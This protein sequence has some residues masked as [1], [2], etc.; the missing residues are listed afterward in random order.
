[1]KNLTIKTQLVLA[2]LF[3]GIL[4]FVVMGITSFTKAE[5]AISVEAF[6][7]LEAVRDIKKNQLEQFFRYRKSDLEVL[8]VSDNV[9]SF[10]NELII[11]HNDLEVKD[12][13]NYPVSSEKVKS[14]TS[15]YH[16]YFQK[17]NDTYGYYDVFLICAKHGHIMYSVAKE[18]DYGENLSMGKLRDSGLG[19]LWKMVTRSGKASLVDMR[20]YAPSNDEPAMFMGV[21]V[22]ENGKQI[23]VLAIQVSDKAITAITSGR[24]GMGDTGE[25]YLV[26]EDK[27]MRSDSFLDPVNHS[28][29]ASFANPAKGSVT[30]DAVVNALTGKT[31]TEIVIDYNN[32]PVL[33]AYQPLEFTKHFNAN[34]KWIVLAEI[35]EA[36]VTI[37]TESLK[38]S[39]LI[40]GVVFLV[41]I[42][43]IALVLGNM[44]SKPIFE[45]VRSI[46]ESNK[47]VVSASSEIS[48][49]ATSLAE[50]ASN[51]ASSVEEVSATIKESTAIN[52][53]NS[54]NSN[55]ADILAKTTK[56]S[57]QDGLERGNEL[58]GA[59]KEINSSSE[60]IS[61]IIKTID[62][63][64]SQ[65][66]LLA[67]NAA[68]EAARAGEHGLGFAVVADEVKSL[69][70]RSADAATETANIIEESIKQVNNGSDIAE[71]ASEAFGDILERINKTSN[72]IGEISISAKEQSQGMNQIA[73]AMGQ[74][75]QVTQQNAATSEE[76]AAAA[77]ELNAQAVSMKDTVDIVG[78]MVGYIDEQ[79]VQHNTSSKSSFKKAAP[80]QKNKTSNFNTTAKANNHAS[81]SN[82]VFPLG[83]DDLKEF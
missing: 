74:I 21:P 68:V 14:V 81:S 43:V 7:K 69:A 61:K 6:A 78:R 22:L 8:A 17:F 82:E 3:V 54:E 26:G 5:S 44:I 23:A 42:I 83:E 66:K 33:S 19:E 59:M 35:D 12:H 10:T 62:E 53:Q 50:G 58:L 30:S 57:A 15:K 9:H 1:M 63:I 36:E 38:M 39:A 60:K 32:N 51:Q 16:D 65:T 77:E 73:S 67:L 40:M 27:L 75:D 45:A 52:T 2:L 49:S 79:S 24:S 31:S 34:F 37:P 18:S 70:G 56:E 13:E 55:E 80:M 29:K 4:P 46:T 20:P 25:V 11:A 41:L 28:L 72:L 64:A 71:K 76:A 47:Q 48:D